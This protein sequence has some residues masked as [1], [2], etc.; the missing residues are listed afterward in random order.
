MELNIPNFVMIE[1]QVL[2]SPYLIDKEKVLY[3]LIVALSNNKQSC[4]F[5]NN[6]YFASVLNIEVRHVQNCLRT[7]EKYNFIV[8]DYGSTRTITPTINSF[9]KNRETLNFFE[10]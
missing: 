5:A 9:L 8:V 10:D 1:K 4:C 2:L 6:K 7:L 3:A